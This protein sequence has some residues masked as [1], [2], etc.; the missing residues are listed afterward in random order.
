MCVFVLSFS[1]LFV[2]YNKN[3]KNTLK[4]ADGDMQSQRE[5]TLKVSWV[6]CSSSLFTA[7]LSF[8]L[9]VQILFYLSDNFFFPFPQPLSLTSSVCPCLSC[10]TPPCS[11]FLGFLWLVLTSLNSYPPPS[12][13]SVLSDEAKD[14]SIGD[15]LW[16]RAQVSQFKPWFF[17]LYLITNCSSWDESFCSVSPF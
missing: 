4:F 10:P 9:S 6:S 17:N 5:T 15:Q 2:K 13:I 1:F 8:C 3:I 12:F 14:V 7:K 11:L 16:K